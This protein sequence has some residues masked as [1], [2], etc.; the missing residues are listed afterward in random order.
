MLWWICRCLLK[1]RDL[2]KHSTHKWIIYHLISVSNHEQLWWG[3]LSLTH[4]HMSCAST[5]TSR[6]HMYAKLFMYLIVAASIGRASIRSA[7]TARV[8]G[9]MTTSY[10]NKLRN[11]NLQACYDVPNNSLA[12]WCFIHGWYQATI[13]LLVSSSCWPPM[14]SNPW[15]NMGIFDD[16][17]KKCHVTAGFWSAMWCQ[18]WP[19]WH[20]MTIPAPRLLQAQSLEGYRKN[21]VTQ[22]EHVSS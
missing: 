13:V 22:L 21:E 2:Q 14:K 10:S 1:L 18:P 4:L 16:I 17:R 20:L 12:S 7:V 15:L 19:F 5:Y 9:I 6:K 11:S 3:F 8:L